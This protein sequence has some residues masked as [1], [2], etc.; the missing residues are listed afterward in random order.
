[1]L[2]K[3]TGIAGVIAAGAILTTAAFAAGLHSFQNAS[4]TEAEVAPSQSQQINRG[5]KGDRQ[6]VV[7]A[8]AR[9]PRHVTTVEVVGVENAAVIYRDRNGDILFKTDPVSN[10]TLV[11]KDVVLPEVTI[12]NQAEAQ[13][14]KM[15]VERLQPVLSPTAPVDGC[16]GA[17]ATH[18]GPDHLARQASRCVTQLA[19]AGRFAAVN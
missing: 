18:T 12:R 7:S 14:Q 5:G 3:A 1:M 13:V 10:V 2:R 17:V 11:S 16:D 4:L 15:P 8:E 6:P 9:Q 19:P